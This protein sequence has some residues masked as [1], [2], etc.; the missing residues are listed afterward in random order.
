[1]PRDLKKADNN[2]ATFMD[3]VSQSE[4]SLYYR[5]PTNAERIAFKAATIGQKKN[6]IID[7]STEAQL[8]YGARILTGIQ[9][10]DFLF[11]G[12][13]ISSNEDSPD[14]N[15]DW[16]KLVLE[17][18]GDLI[19]SLAL[20]AFSAVILQYEGKQDDSSDESG[21]DMSEIPG[22][23]KSEMEPGGESEEEDTSGPLE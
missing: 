18:A 6:K 7:H 3:G 5:T 14:Y 20:L 12:K 17:T 21:P 16:K 15:P 11:D 13:P 4:I 1:M 10:G 19:Q 2:K 22:L 8:S 23:E 9:D